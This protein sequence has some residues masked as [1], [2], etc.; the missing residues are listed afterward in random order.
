M[1]SYLTYFFL[2]PVTSKLLHAVRLP[3]KE[4]ILQLFGKF[5]SYSLF[6]G[7]I[8][9]VRRGTYSENLYGARSP[10]LLPEVSNELTNECAEFPQILHTAGPFLRFFKLRLRVWPQSGGSEQS[11]NRSPKFLFCLQSEPG[12]E[13]EGS[14]KMKAISA[15]AIK[16]P[17]MGAWDIPTSKSPALYAPPD[18]NSESNL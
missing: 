8:E 6:R 4:Q 12:G 13:G 7:G 18:M 5:E 11:I 15:S 1:N 16:L 9:R 10:R 2:N 3:S 14:S 17:S